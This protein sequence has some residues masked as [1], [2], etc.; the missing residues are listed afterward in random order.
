MAQGAVA[1]FLEA[2]DLGATGPRP[3][4]RYISAFAEDERFSTE[5]R[6]E[7]RK[8]PGTGKAPQS[9]F[10]RG[11]GGQGHLLNQVGPNQFKGGW[12]HPVLILKPLSPLGRCHV[13]KLVK[14][15]I[16]SKSQLFAK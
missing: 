3:V 9:G 6:G 5:P 2:L 14:S 15:F 7:G 13:F 12:V 16:F 4:L 10:G 8:P 1:P 11:W